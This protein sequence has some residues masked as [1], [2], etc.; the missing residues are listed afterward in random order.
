MIL[1][2]ELIDFFFLLA[3]HTIASD[4]VRRL[5]VVDPRFRMTVKE[6]LQHP[7]ITVSHQSL[8]VF[9]SFCCCSSQNITFFNKKI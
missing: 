1:L 6:A 4:L 3:L 9:E 5:L 7:W 2:F 8:F